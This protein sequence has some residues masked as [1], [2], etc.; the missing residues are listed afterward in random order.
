MTA[1]L[2]VAPVPSGPRAYRSQLRVLGPLVALMPPA[3]MGLLAVAL[4]HG[5]DSFGRG[6][7]G[8]AT[9]VLAAPGLLIVGA[10]LSTGG[11]RYVL[12]V[13]ASAVAWL[14]LGA[15]A[16]ARATRSPVATWREFW[17]E[18]VWMLV[19]VW[20]GVLCAALLVDFALGNP[21]L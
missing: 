12:A 3:A 14:L 5:N 21:L 11:G 2:A 18:F 17:R 15:L 20:L 6:A 9:A 1:R 10:P 4:L 8:F 16:A 7:A 13:L 19:G